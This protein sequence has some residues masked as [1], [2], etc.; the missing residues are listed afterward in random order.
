MAY[1][2]LRLTLFFLPGQVLQDILQMPCVVPQGQ[3]TNR[4]I[5]TDK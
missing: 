4:F 1:P 5:Y 3:N 2:E